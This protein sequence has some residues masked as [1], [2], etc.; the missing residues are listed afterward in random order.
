MS[1][2]SLLQSVAFCVSAVIIIIIEFS[3]VCVEINRFI[4]RLYLLML[5]LSQSLHLCLVATSL[6]ERK[7]LQI[8]GYRISVQLAPDQTTDDDDDD[9]DELLLLR[10]VVVHDVSRDM[11]EIVSI[12]L[13][14][15]RTNGGPIESECY[16]ED[17]R[18]MSVR[19]TD[20]QGLF[21]LLLSLLS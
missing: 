4:S 14:N 3:D 8:K 9:D 18:E 17:K 6:L 20:Q 11:E 7:T 16:D 15:P 12:Y 2:S 19:F 1:V 21:T 13:E 10:T 5:M